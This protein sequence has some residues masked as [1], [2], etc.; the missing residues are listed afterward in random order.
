M[1]PVAGKGADLG[2]VVV[3]RDSLRIEKFRSL[4]TVND[5]VT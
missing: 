5:A 2:G 4:F 1:G 3:I